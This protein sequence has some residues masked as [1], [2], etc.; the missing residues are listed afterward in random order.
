MLKLLYLIRAKKSTFFIFHP[1]V[2]K[3]SPPYVVDK[4]RG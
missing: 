3:F 4:S 2:V 1:P